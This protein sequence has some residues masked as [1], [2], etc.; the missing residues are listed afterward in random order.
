MEYMLFEEE[1]SIFNNKGN[2]FNPNS[3]LAARMRPKKL[4][5][6]I[7]QKHILTQGSPILKLID[8]DSSPYQ[9][10]PASV[11]LWGPPG[12]GKTTLAQL[13][14]EESG[15]KFIEMSAV[16][17]GV[18]EVRVILDEAKKLNGKDKP[19]LFIDEIHRFTKSQQ[20]ILLPAVENGWVILVA[21]TTEN[22]TFTVVSPLLSRS[23]IVNLR[24]LTEDDIFELLKKSLIDVKGLNNNFKVND[25]VIK[26]IA[27]YSGGDARKALTLLEASVNASKNKTVTVDDLN[28]VADKALVQWDE[29][30]HYD[31]ISAFIKSMRGSDPN[32]TIHYLA[33]MIEA[34][35]DPRFIARRIM[36]AA[37]E[38]VGLADPNVLQVANNAAQAV[39]VIGMPEARIILSQAALS[40]ALAPKSNSAYLAIDKAIQDVREG[41]FGSVPAHLR[42]SQ[43]S[44][45]KD[46]DNSE[47]YVYPHDNP[48]GVVKQQYLPDKLFNKIYYKPTD[49]GREKILKERLIKI[50]NLKE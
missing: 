13:I 17:E 33:R 45:V 34:G 16:N 20:D 38:D 29:G 27:H 40:V 3:P 15:R 4:K 36:I 19:V 48:R 26:T 42:S 24:A 46:L 31:V 44:G 25:N 18:K 14:A 5:D 9:V 43:S 35:E 11:I 2:E 32:A 50:Q 37:A 39:A 49:H 12:T 8:K 1:L 30:Q 47:K 23:L 21:A 28:K 10:T 22:P 41:N 7:G 6:F